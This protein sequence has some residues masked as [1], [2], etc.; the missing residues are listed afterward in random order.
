[1]ANGNNKRKIVFLPHFLSF[2]THITNI[3]LYRLFSTQQIKQTTNKQRT[4][5]T[6]ILKLYGNIIMCRINT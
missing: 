5:R 6:F 2:H 1:M 4:H 3:T